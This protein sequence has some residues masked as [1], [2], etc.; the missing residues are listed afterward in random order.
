MRLDY[1]K[2]TFSKINV[3]GVE[4]E[5]ND[6]RIKHAVYRRKDISMR[7]QGMITTAENR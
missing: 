3:C 4:C 6:M 2:E 7:L 5:F 1:G